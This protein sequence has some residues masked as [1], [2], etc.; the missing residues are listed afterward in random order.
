MNMTNEA[1]SPA[2]L[3]PVRISRTFAATPAQ[4]FAAWISTEQVRQWFCPA[5]YSVPA[6]RVEAHV[7]GAF[8]VCM[9][10]PDGSEHWTRGTFLELDAGN[11]LVI[12]LRVGDDPADPLF[13]AHTVVD[14][15]AVAGGTRIDI[16]QQYA[17][18]HPA[19][20]QMIGGAAVGWKQTLD[21][22]QSLLVGAS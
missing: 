13:T 22:L 15:T 6:A 7:G 1:G 4:V 21:R 19:A 9:R 16:E 14:F 3:P 11:R 17:V 2:P 20:A 5:C 10:A 8:E 12:A 18:Y